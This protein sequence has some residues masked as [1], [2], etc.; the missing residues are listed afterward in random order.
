MEENITWP[1]TSGGENELET[2]PLLSEVDQHINSALSVF[3]LW[4]AALTVGSIFTLCRLPNIIVLQRN[5][6]HPIKYMEE[7]ITWPETS[8]GENELETQPLLSEVDQHINSALSVFILW[9]AALTV[10]SIFTLC[11]LPNII[12][13]LFYRF[14]VSFTKC[15]ELPDSWET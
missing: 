6:I 11:R 12:G 4:L 14:S 10:G 2:Q 3:I 15:R 7:N 5:L 8:G 9:L 1:E 13:T